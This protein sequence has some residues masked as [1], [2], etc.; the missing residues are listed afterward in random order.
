[1]HNE[2]ITGSFNRQFLNDAVGLLT[3]LDGEGRFSRMWDP[4]EIHQVSSGGVSGTIKPCQKYTYET[5]NFLGM[6]TKYGEDEDS[7]HIVRVVIA[8]RPMEY[9]KPP[10]LPVEG[11]HE[12][13]GYQ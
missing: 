9:P 10:K 1:Y 4:K 3:L 2:K 12:T 6:T 11:Y 8:G 13:T 5:G 7:L